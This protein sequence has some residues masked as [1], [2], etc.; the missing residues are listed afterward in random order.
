MRPIGRADRGA[1]K[2]DVVLLSLKR[3]AGRHGGD[4]FRLRL[5]D[6]H[7]AFQFDL[8]QLCFLRLQFARRTS[9]RPGATET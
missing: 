4:V 1:L 8:R 6:R 7:A 5:G 9:R 3:L 2:G